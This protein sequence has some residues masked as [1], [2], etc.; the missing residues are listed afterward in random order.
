MIIDCFFFFLVHTKALGPAQFCN[1]HN[2]PLEN[3]PAD[4]QNVPVTYT[5]VSPEQDEQGLLIK[6]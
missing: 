1:S 6:Q 2:S 3:T 5:Q 4:V